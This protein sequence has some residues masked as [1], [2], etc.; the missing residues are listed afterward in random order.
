MCPLFPGSEQSQRGLRKTEGF[1]EVVSSEQITGGGRLC[2]KRD[3][4]VLGADELTCI[5][6]QLL[7][8]GASSSC[9]CEV[10]L[11]GIGPRRGAIR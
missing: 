7:A 8:A 9:L 3:Q 2:N 1:L 10:S 4:S 5:L 11:E 6:T